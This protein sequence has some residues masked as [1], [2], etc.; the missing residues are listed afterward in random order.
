MRGVVGRRAEGRATRGASTI[1]MQRTCS[2]N[3]LAQAMEIFRH[4]CGRWK[5]ILTSKE[6]GA[7][8]LWQAEVAVIIVLGTE[9]GAAPAGGVAFVSMGGKQA[10][11]ARIPAGMICALAPVS[12]CLAT[13]S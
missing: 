3:G 2:V 7:G 12:T 4:L 9:V 6:L 5:P 10:G 13:R 1:T 8:Y 11:A